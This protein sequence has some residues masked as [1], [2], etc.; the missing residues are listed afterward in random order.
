MKLKTLLGF[1][2]LFLATAYAQAAFVDK[3]SSEGGG[4]VEVNYKN[5]AVEDLI[6]DIVPKGYRTEYGKP[7]LRKKKVSVNSKGQWETVLSTI[8]SKAGLVIKATPAE[9]TVRVDDATAPNAGEGSAT[10]LVEATGGRWEIQ[11]GDDIEDAFSRWA[12]TTQKW[13]LAWEAPKLIAG[14]SINLTGRFEDAV[15]Q[16]IAA[17][18]RNGAG[19][20]HKFYVSGSNHVL[21]IMEKK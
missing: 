8:G 3:R 4:E 11:K 15:K 13:E 12:A 18:N 21:R 2:T 9:K 20:D 5:V 14:G 1:A 19:L 17:L 6:A 10:K 7:E 16:V